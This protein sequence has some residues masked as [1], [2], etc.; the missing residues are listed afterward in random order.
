MEEDP[1]EIGNCSCWNLADDGFEIVWE[2]G[3]AIMAER[4]VLLFFAG[5]ELLVVSLQVPSR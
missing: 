3:S 4:T 2:I 1:D 5:D